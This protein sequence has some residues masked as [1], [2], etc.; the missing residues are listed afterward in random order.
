L[1]MLATDRYAD[2]PRSWCAS[3]PLLLKSLMAKG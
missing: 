2:S 3:Y 1:I